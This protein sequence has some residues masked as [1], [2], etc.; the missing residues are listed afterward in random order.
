MMNY[1]VTMHVVHTCITISIIAESLALRNAL[2][3]CENYLVQ[4]G[5]IYINNISVKV[6][7]NDSL[8]CYMLGSN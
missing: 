4:A 2:M 7:P 8:T 5:L 6:S 1:V 3:S